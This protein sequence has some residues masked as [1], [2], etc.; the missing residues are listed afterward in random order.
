MQADLSASYLP[1]RPSPL[2]FSSRPCMLA[3]GNAQR[4][5]YKAS[6]VGK[7]E[8]G[9]P[10]AK[11]ARKKEKAWTA[12]PMHPEGEAE[13]R[14]PKQAKEVNTKSEEE[15]A[16]GSKGGRPNLI[17]ARV[18]PNLVYIEG[19]TRR[20]FTEE[21][22]ARQLRVSWATFYAAKKLFPEVADAVERGRQDS[23]VLVENALFREAVGY[24]LTERKRKV[25]G[26]SEDGEDVVIEEEVK[27]FRARPSVQAQI[28]Y[29]T[30]RMPARWQSSPDRRVLKGKAAVMGGG[31]FGESMGMVSGGRSVEEEVSVLSEKAG[32]KSGGNSQLGSGEG[33]LGFNLSDRPSVESSSESKGG[34]RD[35]GGG[36]LPTR[37]G[38]AESVQLSKLSEAELEALDG[39]IT[40]SLAAQ[41]QAPSED[42]LPADPDE[43][44]DEEG[45]DFGEMDGK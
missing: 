27:T 40:K 10:M 16:K 42:V 7:L 19:W 38:N 29:L 35:A 37:S 2:W 21:S 44:F 32:G 14:I 24:E 25:V 8:K 34:G 31:A 13:L 6:R 30:N 3:Y 39:L 12:P 15:F 23:T 22:I 20:G 1:A 43:D 41:L 11:H 45:E 36:V 28:F 9:A 33:L 4:I 5:S 17:K 18:L 26:K